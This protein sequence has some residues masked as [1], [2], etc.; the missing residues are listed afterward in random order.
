MREMLSTAIRLRKGRTQN[1]IPDDLVAT[2]RVYYNG[3]DPAGKTTFFRNLTT[4]FGINEEEVN[5]AVA[6]WQHSLHHGGGSTR[7]EQM[8]HLAEQ[9]WQAS[10][11]AY[12]RLWV[13]LSQYQDGITFLVRLRA[14]LLRCIAAKPSGAAPLRALAEGL[15]RSLAEW[16]SVGLLQLERVTWAHSSAAMLEKVSSPPL[17]TC[18]GGVQIWMACSPACACGICR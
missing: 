1:T 7:P 17:W 13:P 15:R 4:H 3:L 11:P 5:T 10:Q 18:L 6:A 14:D 16:F 12:S 8:V 2:L 9:L